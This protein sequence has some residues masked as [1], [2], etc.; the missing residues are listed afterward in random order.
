ADVA[1]L[2]EC[3][4]GVPLQPPWRSHQISAGDHVSG[5][6]GV[7]DSEDRLRLSREVAAGALEIGRVVAQVELLDPDVAVQDAVAFGLQLDTAGRIRDAP[8]FVVA[9][10][11]P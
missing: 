7:R 8:T 6:E 2:D 3:G 1:P 5:R 4:V 11:D 9:A 10:I